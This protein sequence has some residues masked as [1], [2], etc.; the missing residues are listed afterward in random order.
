MLLYMQVGSLHCVHQQF[1]NMHVISNE[2]VLVPSFLE[3]TVS[4]IFLQK[5]VNMLHT[6]M[7]T[8]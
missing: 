2:T 7:I 4:S 1:D 3:Q 5:N 6:I 8:K